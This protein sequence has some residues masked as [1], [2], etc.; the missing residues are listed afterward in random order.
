MFR[1]TY[2]LL[3]PQNGRLS[4]TLE[5]FLPFHIF[6]ENHKL[7]RKGRN[8]L[9]W[10]VNFTKIGVPF[11]QSRKEDAFYYTVATLFL[12]LADPNCSSR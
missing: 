8:K 7:D 12:S 10:V 3:L 4:N 1:A 11:T 9:N 2:L 5:M 6:I